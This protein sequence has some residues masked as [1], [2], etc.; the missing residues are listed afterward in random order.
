MFEKL[1][2]FETTGKESYL[3]KIKMVLI[4]E[5]NITKMHFV[6]QLRFKIDAQFLMNPGIHANC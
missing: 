1:T 5:K 3:K 6:F 4:S 2:H